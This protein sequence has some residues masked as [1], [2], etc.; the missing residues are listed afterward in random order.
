MSAPAEERFADL[1]RGIRLCYRVD[2]P[3]D[4][5][6]LLLV[7][8]LGIDLTSW[9][10]RMVDGFVERGFRVIRFDNRDVGR[11]TF[12]DAPPPTR[13][14]QLLARPRADAYDLGDMAEDAVGLLDS[15]GIE[16]A[17]VVGMS[18]GGMIGQTLTARHPDR[19]LTLTSIFSTTGHRRVGQPARSTILRL[20]RRPPFTREE[21][22]TR[23]LAMLRHI[24]STAFP[25]DEE[26]ERAYAA[27]TWD[28][29]EHPRRSQGVARQIQAIQA[30]GD[31]TAELGGITAPTLVVHGDVDRM[32]HPSGGHAT[33]AAVPGARHVSIPGM[34]HHLAPGVVDRLVDLAATHARGGDPTGGDTS[35]GS[36]RGKVAV[37]T[38]AGSG[39]GRALALELARRGA[40]LALSDVDE[41][42]LAET[43]DQVKPLGA[44]VQTARLD[45]ADRAAVQAYAGEVAE[46]FGV[47][48]QVYN[49][50]GITG[51]GSTVLD[52]DWE[53]YDR[54][55]GVNL[56][57]V[58][59]GTKA[60]LPHLIASGDGHVVNVSSLNGIMGQPTLSAYCAS[61]FG[62]RG[63]TEALRTE[64]LADRQPVQ[65]SVVHP[66]GVK[67][68][69]AS[70]TLRD[71]QARGEVPTPEQLART[72]LYEEKLLRLPAEEAARIVLDGVE[73]GRAR[74]L[75][76]RDARAIDRMVRLLPARYPLVSAW[77][78]RKAFG[79]TA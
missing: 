2:G 6:P 33:A 45:V 73:A 13:A 11:S 61:K 8:G 60:F 24:G 5:E 39:I 29:C 7:A 52:A 41:L 54:T 30:S 4:G 62:V 36:V 72:R 18:M 9:P 70:A 35:M 55:L 22:V 43:A 48:H 21:S 17:H 42:G 12:V 64:M 47:V 27:A 69:I 76:G 49:N 58:I 10:Q 53:T 78:E 23:H 67:T 15:L 79:R 56:F 20:A 3:D 68:G 40:R 65:V 32:V 44:E 51:G 37:V 19:V 57:G 63:F 38:G 46:H 26:L 75:V 71:A 59:H 28:R 14:Q 50:A 16:R 66:G 25:P 77:F 1:G 31:R 34:A 74:I